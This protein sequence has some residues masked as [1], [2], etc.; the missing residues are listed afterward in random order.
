MPPKIVQVTNKNYAYFK[1]SKIVPQVMADNNRKIQRG[2]GDNTN[3]LVYENCKD[4][5]SESATPE[6]IC[7]KMGSNETLSKSAAYI[8]S[9]AI[10][11]EGPIDILFTT[12]IV[13]TVLHL[14][15]ILSC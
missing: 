12:L 9:Q 8:K 5:D 3:Y 2:Q 4:E 11:K 13:S 14:N 1:D 6:V 10:R 7:N 15:Y